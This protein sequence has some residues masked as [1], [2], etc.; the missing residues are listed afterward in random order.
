LYKLDILDTAPEERFDYIT[1]KVKTYF[2]VSIALISIV[3]EDRQWFKSKQGLEAQ[4]TPRDIS[5]CG[6][7]INQPDVFYIPDTFLDDRF[8]DNPLVTSEPYIRFY[9]GSPIR[10]SD[11]YSIGTLCIIDQIPRQLIDSDL[12]VLR[13]FADMVERELA[14]TP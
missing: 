7:A 3:D 13:E 14:N 11:G 1:A 5:F 9:A 10:S 4:Q 2:G 6:H 12:L 8:M